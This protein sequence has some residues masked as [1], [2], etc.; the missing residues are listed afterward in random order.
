MRRTIVIIGVFAALA[1]IFLAVCS[2]QKA[3][4]T[5]A[6]GES[7]LVVTSA[8]NLP[9]QETAVE[10]NG[11]KLIVGANPRI[12]K[13]QKFSPPTNSVVITNDAQLRLLIEQ[14]HQN[15]NGSR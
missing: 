5:S 13:E 7:V 10:S 14:T 3:S 9:P 1:L 2:R 11:Y 12:N 6:P 15:T 4:V 8:T